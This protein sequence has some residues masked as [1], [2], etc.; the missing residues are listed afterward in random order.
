MESEN[1]I[2]SDDFPTSFD[3]SFAF[4]KDIKDSHATLEETEME[5][6]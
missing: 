5:A 1:V 2:E 6:K 4:V 3:Q